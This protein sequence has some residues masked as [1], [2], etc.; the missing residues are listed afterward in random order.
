MVNT[1]SYLC[2]LQSRFYQ[3]TVQ[4]LPSD[5]KHLTKRRYRFDQFLPSDGK[6]LTK[7]R[8]RFDQAAVQILSSG[9]PVNDH[10]QT[11]GGTEIMHDNPIKSKK[12]DNKGE[13]L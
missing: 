2:K 12:Y 3:A 9:G 5:G 8:Y 10:Q 4:F 7:R 11:R 1:S 6:D 13:Y